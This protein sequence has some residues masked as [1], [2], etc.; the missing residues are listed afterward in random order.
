MCNVEWACCLV[1]KMTMAKLGLLPADIL[2]NSSGWMEVNIPMLQVKGF[3]SI[4]GSLLRIQKKNKRF[5]RPVQLLTFLLLVGSLKL[6][7]SLLH[8]YG[9]PVCFRNS[10][11]R[12]PNQ[13]HKYISS[14]NKTQSSILELLL[15]EA[16]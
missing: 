11:L 13:L 5:Q 6:R 4:L 16:S 14:Q 2:F 12:Q 3:W 7:K 1:G 8:L 15:V 10:S 9:V